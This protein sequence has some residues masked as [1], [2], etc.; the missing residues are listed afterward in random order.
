VA[1]T[2]NGPDGPGEADMV[3]RVQRLSVGQLDCLRLVN[4]HL[5]SKEIATELDI[6][7]HT[8]DQRIRGALHILGVERRSQAAR[9][10]AQYGGEYQRLIHQTPHIEPHTLSS[11]P[12]AA[13]GTQIRHADR[14]REAE[15]AGFRTEQRAVTFVPPLQLPFATRS[16][17]RNEMTVGQ[18]LFWIAVIAIGA[19]FSAG[20]YLA[21]LES[22]DRLMMS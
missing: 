22:L 3:A 5:S 15:G 8:V 6:S 13:V 17:P 11:Q 21:G 10:V 12:E 20:M 9:V 1:Q 18:R 7:P 14:A 2:T 19:A 16:N 4:E